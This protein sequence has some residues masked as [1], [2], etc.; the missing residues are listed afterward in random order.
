[1]KTASICNLCREPNWGFICTEC[2]GKDIKD[3]LPQNLSEEFWRFHKEFTG[4]FSSH[5]SGKEYCLKCGKS[6][7]A[8]ICP[9]CYI[10][11]ICEWLRG[12]DTELYEIVRNMFPSSR[13]NHFTDFSMS[14]RE[15]SR[16]DEDFLSEGAQN[17]TFG[18]C[19]ECGEY[20]RELRK[21]EGMWVC[22][23]CKNGD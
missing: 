11:E 6:R 2:L 1:M 9:F 20:S 15:V 23:N 16:E 18:I 4:A 13:H 10:D 3:W 17:T 21:T 14:Y 19:D 5:L 22:E 7:N 8:A 12:R